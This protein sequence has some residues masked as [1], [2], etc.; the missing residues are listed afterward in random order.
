MK[1]LNFKENKQR[2][3]FDFPIDFYHVDKNHIEYVMPII[4]ILNMK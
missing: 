2:G 3:T 4:G 1:Y